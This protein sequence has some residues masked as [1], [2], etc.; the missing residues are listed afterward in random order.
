M[1]D[2]RS[3]SLPDEE[4]K[5]PKRESTTNTSE[6][7]SPYSTGGGG[8]TFEHR[9]GAVYLARLIT[10]HP[11]SEL[12]ERPL[13]RVAFQQA[14]TS[15][16]D[17]LVVTSTKDDQSTSIRLAIACRRRPQFTRGNAKTRELLAQLVRASKAAE[18]DQVVEQR[19]AIALAGRQGSALEVSELARVA[20]N[21]HDSAGFFELINTSGQFSN[22]LRTRLA[23]LRDL[24][25]FAQASNGETDVSAEERCWR[26]LAQLRVLRFSIEPSDDQ[27]WVDLI[28]LLGPWAA[29]GTK[30]SA[31]AL[32][33]Q[34]EALAA[35]Y[36]QTAAAV[37]TDTVRRRLHALLDTSAHRTS[38]G[39]TR[40]R[41]LDAEA[42][43]AVSRSLIGS[44]VENPLKLARSELLTNLAASLAQG[45]EDLVVRGESGVGKSALV[46]DA[47][48]SAASEDDFE[49][50][51][52]NLRDLP[53]TILE[54]VD[55]L[56][57][58]LEDL[59]AGMTAPRRIVVVDAA[60]AATE[61]KKDVFGYILRSARR[62]GVRV[63]A[64][65]AEASGAVTDD[66][67]VGGNAVA[68]FDVPGLSD[69]E[70]SQAVGHFSELDRLATN[71][72]GRELLRRPI[73]IELL[74]RAGG[75]RTPLSDAEAQAIVWQELV[76]SGERHEAGLPDAREEVM[77]ALATAALTENAHQ[78]SLD[79]LDAAAVAGL[80][81]SG[82]LRRSGSLPWERQPTFAHDLLREYAVARVLVARKD[83]A[84]ELR[85]FAAPR[86]ALPAARLA[87]QLLLTSPDNPGDVPD[88][89][90]R[91]QSDFE[92]LAASG[93]GERWVDVPTE[94]LVAMAEPESV[95]QGA[96]DFLLENEAGGVRRLIRVIDLRHRKDGFIDTLVADPVVAQLV[97]AGTPP[98]LGDEATELVKD[99]LMAHV[100]RRTRAGHPGRVALANRIVAQ[101]KDNEAEA[102]RRDAEAAAKR[103]ARSPEEIAAEE[104]RIKKFAGFAE[105]GY[106]RRKRREPTRRRPYEWINDSSIAHLGLLGA[107][108]GS[109]GEAIL[110][111]IAEDDPHKLEPAVETVFAGNAL[112]DFD[113]KL[114]VDLV[115]AYYLENDYEDDDDGFCYGGG[116]H[117][118]GIRHHIFGGFGPLAAF[119]KGPFI[120]LFRNNYRGGV[121][122]L[123]KLL[124]HAARHRVRT[125][126]NIG[127]PNVAPDAEDRYKLD[128]SI[129]G[130]KRTYIGDDHVWLWY[131]GT[132]VGPYPCMS[133]LQALEF[134]NDEIIRAGIP[135]T[136][137][138]P[139]LLDGCDNLAMP[140]LVVGT[141]VR[142]LEMSGDALYPFLVEP[143]VWQLEFARHVHES[144]GL[145]A[146]V[147][148]LDHPERRSWS[149]REASMMLA[150]QADGDRVTA[151]KE[152]GEQL[153]E[154]AKAQVGDN[155]SQAAREH[156]AAVR[157]WAATL[158]RN[159]Y[160]I[161]EHEGQYIIQQAPNPEIEAVL[162]GPS[163]ELLRSNEAMGLTLR[164][165]H[166]RT[167]DDGAYGMSSEALAKDLATAQDLI[168]N[169]PSSG[170][171]TSPDGPVAV[172]ASAI[173]L[174]FARGIEVSTAD[175]EWSARIVL[176]VATEVAA[177]PS[178]TR[179]YS[180]FMQGVD[181]SAAR[182]LPYLLLPKA[183]ALRASLDMDSAER[184]DLLVS[185][186]EAMFTGN[187]NETRLEFARSLDHVWR[188]PCSPNG[189]CHHAVAY[190]LVD[191]SFQ[192]CI[193]GPWDNEAQER[194]IVRLE[195]PV[196]ASLA[197]ATDDR[198][199]VDQLGPAI[200]ALGSAAISD[201]CCRTAARDGLDTLLAAHRR[202][203]LGYK[204]GYMHS[205]SDSL[206]AARAALWQAIDG[207]DEPLLDHVR[208]YLSNTRLLAESL[209]AINAAAEE[210]GPAA[211]EALRLWPVLIDLV[212]DA[213]DENSEILTERRYGDRAF[214]ELIPNPAYAFGYLNLEPSREPV[215]WRNLLGW[216]DQVE[217]WVSMARGRES[218]DALVIAV[219]ELDPAQQV[220]IGL[221]WIETV[222]AASGKD[223]AHT[224]TLPEWLHER[225]ADLSTSDQ[226]A[227]WQRVVDLLVLAGDRR[228]AD[229]AD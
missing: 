98:G 47:M 91:L 18:A 28:S 107:D 63:V 164:H 110:R 77:I 115:E 69:A 35:E 72:K 227:R 40:L 39:W 211:D 16:V 59:L 80:T 82:L 101:C 76:R 36:A 42:R 139:I 175:L 199:L 149:L 137:L 60:E 70:V 12:S 67:K 64:I 169:P 57:A 122:C 90:R 93:F 194:Q 146:H 189:R 214:S 9:V 220:E 100:F 168:E 108:L 129:T 152:L 62:S 32:R 41:L 123:N 61:S 190:D 117:D 133:A 196:M 83:P 200:R 160:E 178:S 4:S 140:A 145:A 225:R 224:Y 134:V 25:Q 56:S 43:A 8:F 208:G 138:V 131:R 94:A 202:G 73:V 191:A 95:L 89:Y 44:G 153:F 173:E 222:V 119:T 120:A 51:A 48:E 203:M 66:M 157:G 147:P 109:E 158:D 182:A 52:V 197:Q 112:A 198:I 49:F 7:A 186:S 58:P 71:P 213:A 215:K 127:Y 45:T 33:N 162:G 1:S 113:T 105:I 167:E 212:L 228:V 88:L 86:W 74:S 161:K 226:E 218:I 5:P 97:D 205:D 229:L 195:P 34:L 223:C 221:S 206:I 141:L 125:L 46:F 187:S 166:K 68:E 135:V 79:T 216:P 132:G 148:E 55:A 204:H 38:E 84:G 156:L 22:K 21:Q 154:A 150:L 6:G 209:R 142:H 121:A 13:G 23:H 85:R 87:C 111:R 99:W 165:V 19:L 92:E 136:H 78:A 171:G 96:W 75:S 128:L 219:G 126:A 103:A 179:D 193:L 163:A 185:L 50:I 54:V 188:A 155:D 114:L 143:S 30:D 29:K 210:K 170:M 53:Q 124:N 37:D 24:V 184:I 192:D 181:R 207:R 17:D 10:N 118:D 217:R 106:P 2:T 81:K 176:E 116:I 104:E 172:A 27:D 159:A 20:R 151:L 65:T 144:S 183:Q 31:T 177:N 15:A 201:V 130:Q 3:G 102:D 11:L 174:F 14:P 26:L 180:F